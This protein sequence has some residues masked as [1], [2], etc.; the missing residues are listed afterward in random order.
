MKF[1]HV[2]NIHGYVF[3]GIE[4]ELD[5]IYKLEYSNKYELHRRFEYDNNGT[6]TYMKCG[7]VYKRIHNGGSYNPYNDIMIPLG[8][9]NN[10]LSISVNQLNNNLK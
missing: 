6:I 4:V 10:E 7:Y 9:M 2:I 3:E 1:T 5:E 8:N